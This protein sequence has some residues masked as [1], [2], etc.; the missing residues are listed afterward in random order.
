[1]VRLA[2]NDFCY[3][4]A[5]PALIGFVRLFPFCNRLIVNTFEKVLSVPRFDRRQYG[6][7]VSLR[8]KYQFVG[9]D[10]PS[11]TYQ[12]DAVVVAQ[13]FRVKVRIGSGV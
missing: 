2:C 5:V 7:V 3:A 12:L 10:T 6:I 11:N 4:G 1:M 8:V 13:V 9:Y